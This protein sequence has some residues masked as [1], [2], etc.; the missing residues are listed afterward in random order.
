MGD[1]SVMVPQRA[2][3]GTNVSAIPSRAPA[4]LRK[5][6]APLVSAVLIA[7]DLAAVLLAAAFTDAIGNGWV[8]ER[9]DPLTTALVFIALACCSG[10]YAVPSPGLVE[11]LRLRALVSITA[12]GLQFLISARAGGTSAAVM[13]TILETLLLVPIGYYFET[14]VRAA[15]MRAGLWSAAAVVVN[16]DEKSQRIVDLLRAHPEIGLGPVGFIAES[17]QR[18]YDGGRTGGMQLSVF[19]SNAALDGIDA[20]VAV[21]TSPDELPRIVSRT[22]Q[23]AARPRL[24][25]IGD[26]RTVAGEATG[27]RPCMIGDAAGFEL[28]PVWGRAARERFKRAIDLCVAVP[29]ALLALPVIAILAGAIVLVSPGGPFYRQ[30]RLGR[31]GKPI[32]ILK[33][34]TMHADAERRLESYL[35]RNPGARAEWE[36]FFKL[37][38]DPRILAFVGTFMR[39]SSLDELPQ[40]WN[41]LRGD[42]T[43]VGPRPFPAYHV[44]A[45]DADF[46]ALRASVKPGLT[47]LWQISFRS[48]GDLG[49]QK[50]QDSFYIKNWSLCLDFYILLQT[51][52]AVLRGEGAR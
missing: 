21:F 25:L 29:L 12:V 26:T 15:L 44:R 7:A 40:I 10:L 5:C 2:A 14:A 51:L 1:T 50:A 41:I 17:G 49:V 39:R 43:L 28:P 33:L 19:D 30:E 45:F 8:G 47:G 46:Q 13:L 38:H 9:G 31:H 34:R 24:L 20:R 18:E 16:C 35:E 48:N 23:D 36:R 11:R 42:M 52:P 22:A 6:R 32:Q 37:K 3:A 27:L 4:I